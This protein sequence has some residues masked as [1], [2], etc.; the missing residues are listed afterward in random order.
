MSATEQAPLARPKSDVSSAVGL[1][2][3]AGLFAWVAFARA[4]PDIAQAFD[5]AVPRD[6]LGGKHSAL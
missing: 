3:L 2:G 5:W 6:T 4:F 1:V